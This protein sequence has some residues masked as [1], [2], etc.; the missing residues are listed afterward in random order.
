MT[1]QENTGQD[2][3]EPSSAKPVPGTSLQ[4]SP[5]ER[6]HAKRDILFGNLFAPVSTNIVAGQY[7]MLF[8]SDVLKFNPMS[9]ATVFALIPIVSILR[10]FLVRHVRRF[11]RIRAYITGR[12][13][14]CSVVL[15]LLVL[16]FNYLS[17]TLLT[18]LLMTFLAAQHL[19]TGMVWSSIIRDITTTADRGRYLGRLQFAFTTATLI[20]SGGVILLVGNSITGPQYRILLAVALVG[21]ANACFWAI[22]IPDRSTSDTSTFSRETA[23]RRSFRY[24]LR[25]S[26]LL[27]LPVLV[28]LLATAASLPLAIV[29]F[30]QVLNVSADLVSLYVFTL[31]LGQV[32]FYY[33]WGQMADTMGFRPMLI[34]LLAL[35]ATTFPII[36]FVPSFPPEALSTAAESSQTLI[37]IGALLL[38]GLSNGI[39][40]SGILIVSTSIQHHHVRPE[41]SLEALNVF[42][43]FQISFQAI[44]L[45]LSGLFLTHVVIPIGVHPV[46][47][48]IIYFDAYK[49]YAAVIGPLLLLLSIPVAKRLP[50]LRPWFKV[51]DFF[52]ALIHS[53]GRT[54]YASRRVYDEIKEKRSDLARW[55]G[56]NANPLVINPLVELLRDPS[57]DVKVEAIRS[58]ARTRSDLAGKELIAL[59]MDSEHRSLWDHTAWALGELKHLPALDLLIDRLSPEM[60]PGIR[61]MSAR[62]LGK[63][64][65]PRAIDFLANHLKKELHNLSIVSAT[66]LALIQL[67]SRKHVPLTLHS[68]LLLKNR[69]DRYELMNAFCEWLEIPS[70]W[71][72]HSTSQHSSWESLNTHLDLYSASWRKVRQP[73]IQVFRKRDQGKLV[74]LIENHLRANPEALSPTIASLIQV[75]RKSEKWSP[76]SVLASAWLLYTN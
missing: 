13:V 72:L 51:S 75:T 31:T 32:L 67:N 4:L 40:T 23:R 46:W 68:L 8:A 76:I 57:Y 19:G 64:G 74:N 69:E 71:L 14:Q 35:T 37:G 59:L 65:D 27:R 2:P 6:Q 26:P 5:A 12:V 33:I 41:D 28:S 39:L 63:L 52:S 21:L 24:I 25:H 54:I 43:I 16:P 17:L 30:R 1:I 55:F 10:I 29:Y 56:V 3:G 48:G 22:R 47:N 60:P 9:I 73:I 36:F 42:S 58:L 50:N 44:V 45:F 70:R 38:L 11:G 7:M 49:I 20:V 53:P 34:G 15:F 18:G 66:S 61:A 62:A